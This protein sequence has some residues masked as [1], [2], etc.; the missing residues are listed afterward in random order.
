MLVT[1]P[2]RALLGGTLGP[3]DFPDLPV[4]EVL[5]SRDQPGVLEVTFADGYTPTADDEARVRAVAEATNDVEITLRQHARTALADNRNFRTSIVP[6]LLAGADTIINDDS[7]TQAEAIAY[8]RDLARAVKSLAN[9]ADT[10]AA[11]IIA[12]G[13]L[14]V[15]DLDAAD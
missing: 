10:Q 3:D 9:Q 13:R 1:N 4:D 7:I 15:Q 6:Q 12:L 11:Q 5:W 8:V 2:R 14:V